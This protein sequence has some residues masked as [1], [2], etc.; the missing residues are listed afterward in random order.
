MNPTTKVIIDM[1]KKTKNE[2]FR[3]LPQEFESRY[4]LER[5]YLLT[6]HLLLWQCGIKALP[7]QRIDEKRWPNRHDNPK[8]L[9]GLHEN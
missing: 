6:I 2:I 9:L 5:S 7:L 1:G 3:L 4:I 8:F